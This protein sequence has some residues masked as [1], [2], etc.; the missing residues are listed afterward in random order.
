MTITVIG[1]SGFLGSNIVSHF[2]K[3]NE[4]VIEINRNDLIDPAINYGTVFYCAGVSINFNDI[5]FEVVDAHIT[6]LMEWLKY[7]KFKKLVYLSSSRIYSGL[8]KVDE[9]IKLLKMNVRDIYNQTKLLGETLCHLSGKNIVLLRLSNV[10]SYNPESPY[11]IWHILRQIKHKNNINLLETAS[12]TRDYLPLSDLLNVI[13][14]I[15]K[16]D[17]CGVLNV[18]S[19][20][21]LSHKELFSLLPIKKFQ[22][23]EY[24]PKENINPEIVNTK[25]SKALNYVFSDVKKYINQISSKYLLTERK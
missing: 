24:G 1:A 18:S 4:H 19:G 2:K 5:P 7:A 17:V 3:S 11:F 22:I 23:V 21:N 15:S 25:I 13:K 14:L 16:S 12:S 20:I 10:T 6:L 8:K 9:D